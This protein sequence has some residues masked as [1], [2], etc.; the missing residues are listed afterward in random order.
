MSKPLVPKPKDRC[1]DE[2]SE[3]ERVRCT[4]ENPNFD[5]GY[6]GPWRVCKKLLYNREKCGSEVSKF[7]PSSRAVCYKVNYRVSF[8]Y[9]FIT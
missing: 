8:H 7:R 2:Q 3:E 4:F 6:F 1:D 5:Q 9:T